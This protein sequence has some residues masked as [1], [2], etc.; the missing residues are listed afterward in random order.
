MNRG[1]SDTRPAAGRSVR[2]PIQGMDCASCAAKIERALAA[3]PGVDRAAVNF[4][5]E[6]AT[7]TLAPGAAPDIAARVRDLGYRVR[8]RQVE[9]AIQGMHCAPR[10]RAS[11][12]LP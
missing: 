6:E 9:L 10:C 8:E 3:V 7:V 4:A 12:R 11:C 5:A 1:V 2:L